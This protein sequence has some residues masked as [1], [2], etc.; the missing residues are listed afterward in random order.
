MQ[1]KAELSD[2]SEEVTTHF[3]KVTAQRSAAKHGTAR[4]GTAQAMQMSTNYQRQC[5]LE[6]D[7]DCL[8]DNSNSLGLGV[9][10][11]TM[12]PAACNSS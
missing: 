2:K 4:H 5:K 9:S 12:R 3:G 8:P 11:L 10:G 6:S 1:G 7:L